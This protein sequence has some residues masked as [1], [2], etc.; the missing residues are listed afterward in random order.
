M[1]K[2]Y[3]LTLLLFFTSLFM[4]CNQES[5]TRDIN[6]ASY[7]IEKPDSKEIIPGAERIALYYPLLKN[8]KV[9]CVVNHTSVIK[10]T[11][12]IDSLLKM[13]V[14]IKKV[15]APEH[16]FR[17]NKSDGEI[18]KNSIDQNTGMPIIS[19]YGEHKKPTDQDLEDIDVVVFDIQDVGAR[20]YTYL[21][22]M[23]YVMEACAENNTQV[24]VL[25]RPNPHL[26][27]VDG[28][29]L[30]SGFSSFV[31]LHPVPVVYGMTIGEYAKMINGEGWLKDGISADL[32]VIP[33]NNFS[34]ADYYKIPINP[35]PN[36][37]N[38]RSILLYPSLCFFEGTQISV[39]RGTESQFQ[40]LGS[41]EL[42]EK[43]YSFTPIS[44]EGSMYPP[45]EGK[46]CYGEDL[47]NLSI[48]SLLDKN[49]IDLSWLVNY[50]QEC[51][52]NGIEFFLNTSHFDRLAGTDELKKQI[53]AGL[54]EDDIRSSW[55]KDLIDF[56]KIRDKYLIYPPQDNY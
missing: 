22:T 3:F 38:M 2:N 46:T 13:N 12:L 30:K 20:F 31:G 52:A 56:G 18:V 16:G 36:L 19:L 44:N 47:R 24:I 39:G 53:V 27:Y 32:R 9:A 10:Q 34:R 55:Q 25:D 41:P 54:S 48:G 8:K 4:A 28:P 26:D 33:V 14:D 50:Y 40:V 35:S 45:H 23:H 37:P 21:S 49:R 29:V 15:F 43:N 42:K 51:Q 17:G 1:I 6:V 11:H 5:G 7:E